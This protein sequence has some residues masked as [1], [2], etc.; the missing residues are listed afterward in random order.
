MKFRKYVLYPDRTYEDPMASSGSDY[1]ESGRRTHMMAPE[2]IWQPRKLW[3]HWFF[4]RPRIQL[5]MEGEPKPLAYR[6]EFETVC[7]ACKKEIEVRGFAQSEMSD[8][9]LYANINEK[10]SIAI[11]RPGFKWYW[12]AIVGLIFVV[13]LLVVQ[14]MGVIE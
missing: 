11:L 8:E 2:T 6:H 13:V 5:V 14:L 3:H 4:R 9:R 7:P 10:H 1:S 12:A